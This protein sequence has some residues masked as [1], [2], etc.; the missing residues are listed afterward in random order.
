V[1]D[2]GVT[3]LQI[4]KGADAEDDPHPLDPQEE[5]KFPEGLSQ[6]VN[7][8]L[9]DFAD[10]FQKMP[11]RL[12]DRG[13][14]HVIPTEPGVKP[15][16]RPSYRLSP[17]EIK[18]VEKQVSELLLQGLIEPSSSPYGAPVLFV[19]KKDGTL[20]MCLDYRLLNS[21]TIKSKYPLP[22]ID[23]LIDQLNGAK[24]LSSLDLQSGYY[25][26]R[27]SPE[28]VP[29]TA[30]LTP[31]G[32]YQFKVMSFGL[33]NAPST[34]QAVMNKIFR[35]YL[36]KFMCVYLDDILI[37]S[38]TLAEHED[39][40]KK[41]LQVLREN[42]FYVKL[43]KCDFEKKELKFLGHMVGADGV[44]VDPAK[45]QVVKDWPVPQNVSHVRSFL[46]LANYF[47]KF[48]PA[49]AI[50]TAPLIKLTRKG[51]VWGPDTWTP[52]CQ[53]A[54]EKVKLDL[55]KAPTL[56][57]PDY[58]NPDNKHGFEVICDAS[59]VGIGSVLTQHG[60]P[61]AFE[62]RKLTDPEKNWSTGDQELW[63][64]IHSLKIWRCY[65]EG[66]KF[67][68]VTD[69]NPLTHLQTQPNLSRRQARWAEFLQRFD[70]DWNYRPGR[71]NV[72]DP[73]SRLPS[74]AVLMSISA[75][76][77]RQPNVRLRDFEAGT[78]GTTAPVTEAVNG[79]N[80][81]ATDATTNHTRARK[82]RANKMQTMPQP[83]SDPQR[84]SDNILEDIQNGYNGDP[85]FQEEANIETL[86]FRDNLWYKGKQVV[87][88]DIP[89]VRKG[90][91][92]E[93][94]DAPYSGHTGVLK[95]TEKVTRMFW[96]PG[97]RHYVKDYVK[98]C[99]ACQ[100]NKSSNQKPA[101]LLQPL[102]IPKRPWDSVSMDFVTG[103]PE[104]P[105]GHDAII[106]FVDRL[107]KMVHLVA[108]TTDVDAKGTAA[109]FRDHVWK[110][111]GLPLDIVSDRGSVFVGNFF[112]ALLKLLNVT[113]NRST[114]F[115]PQTD[116]QT[117]RVNRVMEEMLRHYVMNSSQLTW[118]LGLSAAEFA[119]NNSYH[120]SIGTTPF[121]ANAGRDPRLPLTVPDHC[122]AP[123]ALNFAQVLQDEL[124]RATKCLEAAQQRQK[125]YADTRRR[126]QHFA[127][128]DEILLRTTNLKLR[129]AGDPTT[130]IKLLPKWVGPFKVI[131]RIGEV[132]YKV[133]LPE[134]WR[135]HPVFHVSLLKPYLTDSARRLQPPTP[136][137]I[138]GEAYFQIDRIVDHRLTKLGRRVT[139]EYLIRWKDFGPEHNSWEPERNIAESESGK[140]LKLYWNH[141]GFDSPL[142]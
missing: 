125:R 17:S 73:L 8:V 69:H 98:R 116:G 56:T 76:R 139:R 1:I 107:T 117:E 49:Y 71:D 119:I 29:K 106:V 122:E 108:T 123:E 13:I 5:I 104:M 46:G 70:F 137:I 61:I 15:A 11:G 138:D 55:T 81:N 97:V 64:V 74:Q 68:V 4:Y 112:T 41:V 25:Q 22:R 140:T 126:E 102:P 47:R 75:K 12:V 79:A 88:P 136:E 18:E 100:R 23:Q 86:E 132:A 96:W 124:H 33:C 92:H 14:D 78:T 31:F 87:V 58:S 84:D 16:F 54:F 105:N 133:Q 142:E 134:A 110:L 51:L 109:L 28:D 3:P 113:H 115:H 82:P 65:L 101:G 80:N 21:Q 114:A 24:I 20:R 121:R 90:I 141:L 103:L 6:S 9:S 93:L 53:E 10:V 44:K 77:V 7:K 129:T 66:I 91:L 135:I 27:I 42:E 120:E 43:S 95:T 30:F 39:H 62:S 63:A 72:A 59:T 50:V 94:H 118:E 37:Y 83:A 127:V 36:N 57:T 128:G 45:T 111:H 85:W 38:K 32:Q 130:T 40:L 26:I 60:L 19:Q 131:Q 52:E 34:F 2:D 48:L 99:E 89:W 35:P 67:T